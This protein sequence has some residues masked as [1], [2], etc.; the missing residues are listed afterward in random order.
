VKTQL[1]RA[2]EA[3]TEASEAMAD[4]TDEESLEEAVEAYQTYIQTLGSLEGV[5][6][7]LWTAAIYEQFGPLGSVGSLLQA[8]P[9]ARSLGRKMAEA[10]AEAQRHSQTGIIDLPSKAKAL[11][12]LR[13]TLIAE[14]QVVAGNQKVAVFLQALADNRATLNLLTPEVLEWLAG[15]DALT[16]LKVTAAQ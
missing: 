14:Q 2:L 9:D 7:P 10:A 3:G 6:R 4:A 8:F 1:L 15:Q 5:V 16:S 11:L 13:E 12:E